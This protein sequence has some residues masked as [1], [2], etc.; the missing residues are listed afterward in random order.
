M[1]RA[2]FLSVS[3]LVAVSS[4]ADGQSA[5]RTVVNTTVITV[6][7]RIT[8]T[9]TVD[10]VDAAQVRLPDSITVVPFEVIE[11][12][13]LPV[14]A[15]ANGLRSTFELT[16]TAFELGELEVPAIPVE[17]V[18]PTGSTESLE[19]D[20]YGIEVVSV[21]VD[22]TGDI[23]EIRGPL[24]IPLSSW[25]I[26]LWVFVPLL[27]AALLYHLMRRLGRRQEEAPSP[28]LG[29]LPRP[30]HEVALEALA[31]LEASPLLERGQVKEYHIAASDILRTY[32]E[33]RFRVEALE[34][35]TREVLDSLSS[36]EADASFRV[37]LRTFLEA[38]DLV[39]FA[40]ARPGEAESRE[41]LE[42]GRRIILE[43]VRSVSG[44]PASAEAES[45][46]APVPEGV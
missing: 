5:V 29:P 27:V 12:R 36:A 10:H 19:T 33:E 4:S 43:S 21:G 15:T 17:I 26:A 11:A 20:R 25:V 8:M 23:R 24:G 9:V 32:V 38:C 40:K 34:M 1:K 41:A 28:A 45:G 13:S 18:G 7:D 35:T 6:G 14:E 22:E 39:K 3:W 30:P 2:V 46:S 42:L 44:E 31:R 37:G 16:M